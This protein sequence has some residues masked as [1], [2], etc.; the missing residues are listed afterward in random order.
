MLIVENAWIGKGGVNVGRRD[1]PANHASLAG[2]GIFYRRIKLY[3]P[4]AIVVSVYYINITGLPIRT[5][6]TYSSRKQRI[7]SRGP[8]IAASGGGVGEGRDGRN[9]RAAGFDLYPFAKGWIVWTNS[10]TGLC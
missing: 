8:V 5:N 7:M 10:H 4:D 9:S 3:V 2:R 6:E 1:S